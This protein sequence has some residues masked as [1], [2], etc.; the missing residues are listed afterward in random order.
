MV[1]VSRVDI[2]HHIASQVYS[3]F[4]HIY[5]ALSSI[6]S[7]SRELSDS[8]TKT[9]QASLLNSD[10]LARPV[11]ASLLTH[12]FFRL[13]WVFAFYLKKKIGSDLQ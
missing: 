11:L 6:V 9:L 4:S 12:D 10:P 1:T 3:T 13:V 7:V 2:Q 8:L 5:H